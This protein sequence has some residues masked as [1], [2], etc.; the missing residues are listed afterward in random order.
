MK[1]MNSFSFLSF[2]AIAL[3]I[4]VMAKGAAGIEQ[5]VDPIQEINRSFPDTVNVKASVNKSIEFCPDN[6][7]DFFIAKKAVSLDTLKDFAY[8]YI[9]FY[10]DYYVLDDW[11]KTRMA[12]L[13]TEKILSKP[14]YQW[15]KSNE[16]QRTARRILR[17]LSR[18]GRIKLY[19]VRYDENERSV[20][21]IDIN[22][23]VGHKGK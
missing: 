14:S 3:L 2:A 4:M 12:T 7:C 1:T 15:C 20:V 6:T 13:I 17:H 8:L 19:A 21:H 18:K 5:Q 23:V 10:S 11:R 9:Y 16:Q 22:S